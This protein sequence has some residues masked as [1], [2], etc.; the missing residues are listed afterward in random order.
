MT[1]IEDS[2]SVDSNN[3]SEEIVNDSTSFS[4][5]IIVGIIGSVIVV[6]LIIIFIIM[7]KRKNSTK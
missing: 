5:N 1:V 4:Q 3:Q 7:S 6:L 2:E